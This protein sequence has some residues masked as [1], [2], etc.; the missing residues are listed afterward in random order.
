MPSAGEPVRYVATKEI[1]AAVADRETDILVA[2]GI[3]WRRGRPHIACPYPDHDDGNPSWRWDPKRN[4]AFCT[5]I[6]DRKSNGIF[7]IIMKIKAVDFEAAKLYAAEILHRDDLI[8]TKGG[9]GIGSGQKTD[10]GSLLNPPADNRDDGLPYCYLAARLGID[11]TE[12]PVPSTRMIGIKSLGYFAPS[13]KNGKAAKPVL[14]GH[15][16][17]AVFEQISVD[18]RRHAQ[19]IYLS[20]DGAG[21]AD[22]GQDA[23][24]KE[25]DPKKSAR[26][27]PQ[28]PSTA[29]C[30]VVWG[31]PDCCGHVVVA[32]GI[33]NGSA[34][35]YSFSDEIARGELTVASAITAGGVEAFKPWPSA[36]RITI[37]ADRDEKKPGAGFKRGE[38]AART[39]ALRLAAAT[40]GGPQLPTLLALPGEPGTE[41]DFLD[42][43]RAHGIAG[44]RAAIAA[45]IAIEPTE[46]ETEIERITAAYP[47]PPLLMLRLEYR[48]TRSGEIWLHKFMGTEKDKD[49][50]EP[51]EIWLPI[52]S[53]I[54][55]A[56]RLRLLDE[57]EVYGLR[58]HL[59]DMDGATR[60]VDFHRAELARLAASEI[61]SRLMAAGLRVANGGEQV[62]VEILK[63]A[64]PAISLDT[65]SASGWQQQRFIT[66]DSEEIA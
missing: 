28:G 41:T 47:I 66:L 7:D 50:G 4:C 57:D 55:P 64:R 12:V 54:T 48:A 45:A 10:P 51:T 8:K 58:V 40:E 36:R 9:N 46:E 42:V 15:W 23:A 26:R 39:L 21:K 1:R 52:C 2:L 61:R 18:G 30:C 13:L 62:I 20:H 37:A 49:T 16:P 59:A 33:E 65:A 5:C 17:C 34:I 43:L 44:V 3:D 32:E 11:V 29:G 56:A 24:G 60:P 6:T 38:R 63:E 27:D 25:R 31:D 35:A 19:R 22:L 14:V 53:P